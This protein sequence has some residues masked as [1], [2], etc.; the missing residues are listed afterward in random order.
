MNTSAP[1]GLPRWW[2]LLAL[3]LVIIGCERKSIDRALQS[4]ANGYVCGSCQTRF[5]T[6]HEIFPNFCPQCKQVDFRQVVGYVCAADK[7]VTVGPR[8]RSGLPCEQ[9]GQATASLCIPNED[10]LKAWGAARKTGPE[11][12]VN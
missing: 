11:V 12:G 9:C 6:S 4:D 1:T 5:Y 8:G 7:H 10:N 2:A 3:L